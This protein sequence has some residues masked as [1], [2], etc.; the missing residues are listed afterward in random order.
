VHKTKQKLFNKS[1]RLA[2]VAFAASKIKYAPALA[3]ACA[4]KR[5]FAIAARA[6]ARSFKVKNKSN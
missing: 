1:S 4:V 3:A 6:H 2:I 5:H